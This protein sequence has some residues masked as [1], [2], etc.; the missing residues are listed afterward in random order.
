MAKERPAWADEKLRKILSKEEG[1]VYEA[2]GRVELRPASGIG[3]LLFWAK[4]ILFNILGILIT[5]FI[6]KTAWM[7]I[8]DRRIIILTNDKINFPLW[9]IPF[10]R[11][12]TDYILFRTNIASLNSTEN[13]T[14]WFIRG[15]GVQV[16][17]SGGL[18]IYFAG[19]NSK[20]F[21]NLQDIIFNLKTK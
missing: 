7:V 12:N 19:I 1:V 11:N 15:K 17:T 16:E 13:K 20:D 21:G 5:I 6:R 4:Y 18:V 3:A 8:T 14:F 2:K 10:A 9:I